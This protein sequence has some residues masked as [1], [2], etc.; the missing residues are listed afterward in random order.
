MTH[1]LCPCAPANSTQLYRSRPSLS[2]PVFLIYP[3]GSSKHIIPVPPSCTRPATFPSC[4][5]WVD[6]SVHVSS[7]WNICFR[8][9]LFSLCLKFNW[10][11]Q[12]K[13]QST[14]IS[15]L[16]S[17]AFK[18]FFYFFQSCYSIPGNFTHN[19]EDPL[20]F[21]AWCHSV[22]LQQSFL[23]C[24]HY[25][26]VFVLCR[27]VTAVLLLGLFLEDLYYFPPFPDLAICLVF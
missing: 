11:L 24:V 22:N 1:V 3:L 18:V 14:S 15:S 26:L 10:C 13:R 20:L 7:R 17:S 8:M 5:L 6:T 2:R 16:I 9:F 21:C 19:P 25:T 23:Y 27:Y 12:Y 4:I